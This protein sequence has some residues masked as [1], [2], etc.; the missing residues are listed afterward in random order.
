M[1]ELP[2]TEG[3]LKIATEAAGGR[4]IT[5]IHLVVGEL[6][7]IIDDSVQFYFDLLSKGTTAEGA[8]LDFLRLPATVTCGACG[9]R[10]EVHAPL[11][12]LCPECGS[13]RLQVTGGRELRVD[14]IEV[15]D[16]D[17]D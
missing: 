1:H 15:S 6:S 2:I 5:T 7:S 4:K 17:G 9:K 16:D 13:N 10:H 11:P 3:I 14:S 12:A 8:T